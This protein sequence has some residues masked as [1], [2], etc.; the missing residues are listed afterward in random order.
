METIFFED[1]VLPPCPPFI[2]VENID[3]V[4]TI[5]FCIYEVA[6]K[7]RYNP[8]AL[9]RLDL[10]KTETMKMEIGEGVINPE[11]NKIID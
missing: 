8:V 5:G 2:N 9:A 3:G 6:H 1:P 7:I 10:S 11:C 4:N